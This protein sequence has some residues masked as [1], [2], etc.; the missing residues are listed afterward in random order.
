MEFKMKYIIDLIN[1]IIEKNKSIDD[2]L[3]E[4]DNQSKTGCAGMHGKNFT[5]YLI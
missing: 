3:D 1:Y 2:I 5:F 4:Q